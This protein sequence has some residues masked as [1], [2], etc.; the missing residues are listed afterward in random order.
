MKGIMKPIK[1]NQSNQKK[2]MEGTEAISENLIEKAN[3]GIIIVQDNTVIY[4]NAYMLKM[5]GYS[6]EELIGFIFTNL[7]DSKYKNQPF[8]FYECENSSE[9]S[10]HREIL[11]KKKNGK[12][13]MV[14]ISNSSIGYESGK[15]NMLIIRDIHHRIRAEESLHKTSK[16][17]SVGV[18]TKGIAHDY[19]NLLTVISGYIQLAQLTLQTEEEAYPLLSKAYEASR[20]AAEI[21][22]KLRSISEGEINIKKKVST[23]DF[24]N[25]T[26]IHALN[27]TDIEYDLHIS[28]DLYPIEVDEM[29]MAQV[30]VELIQ[31]AVESMSDS[32]KIVIGAENPVPNRRGTSKR[33]FVHIFIK[34]KG[35]GISKENLKKIFDP[36]Y[37][38]KDN[39]TQ[40]GMGLALSLCYS[41]I[42]S[43]R[44]H[45]RVESKEGAGTTFHIYLPVYEEKDLTN[46]TPIE[47]KLLY[48]N[49]F[50][51]DNRVKDICDT[52]MS[53]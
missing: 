10:C 51:S 37:S 7:I 28:E 6:K 40:K 43:H 18:L 15:L 52:F 12:S 4:S 5:L 42:K 38:T 21:I 19:N 41:I 49:K 23:I 9:D 17:E 3:D 48:H 2:Q 13:M 45:I 34:D 11:L 20:R 14:E 8:E 39:C 22:R 47:R 53:R 44:G 27:D 30:I 32:G 24:L 50:R 29:R 16:I 25:K 46:V 36:Y 33:K 31:N 1:S 26:A 35:K